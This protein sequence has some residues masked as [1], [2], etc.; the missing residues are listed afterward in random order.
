MVIRI[1][2]KIINISYITRN[3]LAGKDWNF[4]RPYMVLIDDGNYI[5]FFHKIVSGRNM[6]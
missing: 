4:Y 2:E 5:S 6:M 3:G 1:I